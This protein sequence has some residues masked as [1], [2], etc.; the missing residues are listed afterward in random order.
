MAR[1][2]K[3]LLALVFGM[4]TG[5]LTWYW[6]HQYQDWMRS[7]HFLKLKG[8]QGLERNKTVLDDSMLE[9][10]DLPAS[11]AESLE[12]VA[13][14]AANWDLLI[15]R[16]AV[17]D[18]Q[19]GSLLLKQYFEPETMRELSNQITA[20]HRAMTVPVNAESTV[21]FFVRPGSH[22]DIIGTVLITEDKATGPSTSLRAETKVLLE[23]VQ[24]LAVGGAL[25]YLEYQ[26]I[27]QRGYGT[28]TLD[29]TPEQAIILVSAQQRL[30]SP[31]TLV[32]RSAD[33]PALENLGST[34]ATSTAD[35]TQTAN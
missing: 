21:G 27:A 32:L 19:G 5:V 24:V 3:W 31:L 12:S 1:R 35:K 10:V 9:V 22:V 6:T 13:E 28:V 26:R 8:D 30:N 34:S 14:P 33:K 23:D 20:G 29:V 17:V 16:Q 18:V 7:A 11:F 15:G 4:A 2:I 25:S